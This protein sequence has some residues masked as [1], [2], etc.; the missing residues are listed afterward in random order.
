MKCKT[1][2]ACGFRFV[3]D[4]NTNIMTPLICTHSIT[5]AQ[6]TQNILNYIISFFSDNDIIEALLELSDLKIKYNISTSI[7]IAIDVKV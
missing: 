7:V 3:L 5:N 4:C 2:S 6:C 1:F